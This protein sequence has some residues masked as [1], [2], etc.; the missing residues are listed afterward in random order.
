MKEMKFEDIFDVDELQKL[1]DS[2][3]KSFEVGMGIRTPNGDR[4]ICDIHFC[5]FCKSIV[6]KSDTGRRQCEES[7][8]ILSAS[9]GGETNICRCRSAGLIDAGIKLMI[10]DVHIATILVGQIRLKEN[11]LSL[12]E[13]RK[14]ARS[15]NIDEEIYLEGINKIPIVSRQKFE[16]ILTSLKIIANQLSRLGYHNL[17]QKDTIK[18]FESKESDWQKDKQQFKMMAEKDVLTGLYNRSKFEEVMN[19][20]ETD[21]TGNVCLISG[22]ANNLK[23][24]N[25]IFG[26]EAGDFMLKSVAGKL[27]EAAKPDWYVARCG[28]DEYRVLMPNTSL[29]EAVDYCNTVAEN[30]KKAKALNLPL[31]IALG[32]ALWERDK[33]SLKECFN[34]ADKKM[35]E[36][37]KL[38]KQKENLLDYILDKL[39]DRQYLKRDIVEATVQT[40]YDFSVYLGFNKEGAQRVKTAAKYQDIGYIQLSE[41]YMLYGQEVKADELTRLKEHVNNG[42]KIALQFENT[43]KV[44]EIILYSHERWDG[45]GYPKGIGGVQI[46]MESRLIRVVKKYMY[47]TMGNKN[48]AAVSHEE[49]IK[50]MKEYAGTKYDPDMLKWFIDYIEKQKVG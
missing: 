5:D 34:R 17:L 16:S 49:A 14:I 22:D 43:Y 45:G 47:L 44:A 25:D 42:Y 41:T 40:A 29:E 33:E 20:I 26:H 8:L 24:M 19:K 6:Q 31:S 38:M 3:S 2:L 30:C 10:G 27:R 48:S 11:D 9:E 13:Y 23:L 32:A 21:S 50:Y 28:G 36:N 7:D 4:L 35:Y 37:K 39:Y 12:E 18:S 1:M 15:L 46:P